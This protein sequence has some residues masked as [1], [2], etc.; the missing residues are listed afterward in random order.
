MLNSLSVD[1]PTFGLS[2]HS[3]VIQGGAFKWE[4]L[5]ISVVNG[6]MKKFFT[7]KLHC[8]KGETTIKIFF[9]VIF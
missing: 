3:V 9:K 2:E 4:Y 8:A 6:Y 5:N 7:S 1:I